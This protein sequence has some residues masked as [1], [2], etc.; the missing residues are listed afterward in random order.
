MNEFDFP[1]VAQARVSYQPEL[2]VKRATTS[3]RCRVV[4]GT[5]GCYQSEAVGVDEPGDPVPGQVGV[6][7]DLVPLDDVFEG[8]RNLFRAVAN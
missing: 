8:E 2:L 7:G 6:E 5:A 4:Q 3:G 1:I